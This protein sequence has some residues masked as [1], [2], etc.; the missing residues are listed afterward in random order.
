M[1]K[2]KS[3]PLSF[4]LLIWLLTALIGNAQ[5][6]IKNAHAKWSPDG[7]WIAFD[8]ERDGN[9]DIYI[10]RPD[11]SDLTRITFDKAW[12]AG[13]RWIDSKNLVFI[14]NIEDPTSMDFKKMSFFQVNVEEK[15]SKKVDFPG[16]GSL[17]LFYSPSGRKVALSVPNDKNGSTIWIVDSNGENPKKLISN[18]VWNG[19]PVWHPSENKLAFSSNKDGDRQLYEIDILTKDIKQLTNSKG[20]NIGTSYS[21]K[22][23][24]LLFHSDR[25]EA[26]IF[27]T[28]I[29]N[30]VILKERKLTRGPKYS[31]G[32]SWSSDGKRIVFERN[33]DLYLMDNNGDHL[34][35]LI[36]D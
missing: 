13:P 7:E 30:T 26:S 19:M 6:D 3:K 32:P 28:Y 5:S 25:E 12:E 21:P 22:G 34:E 2:M 20:R 24:Q 14:A 16:F 31:G 15:V 27:H 11:G 23:D 8:S 17:D 18:E 1:T 10:I 9:T 36:K 35:K 4:Y 29:I 33:D